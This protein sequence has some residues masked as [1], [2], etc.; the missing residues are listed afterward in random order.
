MKQPTNFPTVPI[1]EV[2]PPSPTHNH[3]VVLVVDDEATIADSL[4]AILC[5]CGFAAMAAYDGASALDTALLVPPDLVI[6]DVVMPG[7]G[8]IELAIAV[9]GAIPGCKVILFSGHA[10]TADLLVTARRAGHSFT[11]L[12]KPVHPKDLL[13]RISEALKPSG[14]ASAAV[15]G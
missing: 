12:S 4:A 13:A 11:L 5:R 2:P 15:P 14:M 10:A 9:Q 7:M 3:P 8:G 6:T 1:G